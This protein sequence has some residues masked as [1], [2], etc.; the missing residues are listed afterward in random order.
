MKPIKLIM[1]AFGPYAGNTEIDF[2]RMGGRGLYL[3]TGDTG[4]GKTTIFDAIV[5]ALYGEASGEVRRADMF[6]SKY[7]E[8]AVP[9]YVEY[10]FAYREKY[11]T[12]KRNPEYQRPKGRGA[13]YTVQK[14]DAQLIYPDGR[15]PVTKSKEVTRTVTE[16]VG[17]DRKQFTQ[18]AMIAQGDFQKLLFAGTEERSDIFR[19]IFKTSL[20]QRLQEQLKA[21]VKAQW[22]EY[23]ELRRSINQYMDSVVCGGDTP[24]A[25]KLRELQKEKFD[26]RIGDG[27]VLLEELCREDRAALSELDK[28]LEE[29]DVQIQKEDQ[30]IGNIHKIREQ[31]EELQKNQEWLSLQQ[32][33]LAEAEKRCGE[34]RENAKACGSLALQIKEQ[35][36]NL[37]LFD[38]MQKEREALLAQERIIAENI[39]RKQELEEQR[40][41]LEETLR[42]D[43]EN[44]KKLVS[45]GE[46]RER[47]EN[48]KEVN[49]QHRED[50]RQRK[51]GLAQEVVRQ[52]DTE[53]R[54]GK[55]GEKAKSLEVVLEEYR[56]KIERLADRDTMLSSA[57][58]LQK[59]LSEQKEL[60]EK[61]G[62]EW[63]AVKG[64]T[65]QIRQSVAELRSKEAA[66]QEAEEKRKAEQERLKNAGE[67]EIKCGH[68]AEEARERLKIFRRQGDELSGLKEDVKELEKLCGE[69]ENRMQEHQKKQAVLKEEWEA[70]K[71]ADTRRILWEQKEKELEGQRQAQDSLLAEIDKLEIRK[72]ELLQAQEE[73]QKAAVEKEQLSAA[74]QKLE[75]CFLGAQA[76]L[77]AQGLKEGRACPVC[78][79]DHHPM[80]AGVPESV[81]EKKDLDREKKMLS[82]A[83]AKAE[84]LSAQ[85][86]HLL[87]RQDEQRRLVEEQAERLFGAEELF[88]ERRKAGTEEKEQTAQQPDLREM[89][90]ELRQR[91]AKE[92]EQL[93]ESVDRTE[94]EIV[95]KAELEELLSKG[96][97]AQNELDVALH[98]KKQEYAAAKGKLEEKDRQWENFLSELALPG[99]IGRNGDEIEKYLQQILEQS[100]KERKQA[101]KEKDRFEE[102]GK[103]AVREEKE[104][105]ICKE[106][107]AKG[108][109][110]AADLK[111]QDR[112]LQKQLSREL[113]KAEKLLKIAAAMPGIE[114]QERCKEERQSKEEGQS[115]E[116]RQSM[117]KQGM[118]EE[119]ICAAGGRDAEGAE[120]IEGSDRIAE[121]LSAILRVMEEACGRLAMH[122]TGLKGEIAARKRLEAEREEKEAELSQS[123]TDK[124]E[125]EKQLE[126]ISNRRCEKAEQLFRSLCGAVP[127]LAGEY[128]EASMV[129]EG[130]L[131]DLADQAE[132]ELNQ[133]LA[134]LE[135]ELEENRR[136]LLQKQLLDK[137]IPEKEEQSKAF[138]EN[139]RS[140]E[141]MLAG[142]RAACEAG[143]ERME[144]MQK[145]LGTGKREDV[146]ERIRKL[147]VR[148][149]ELE[150]ALKE[151]ERNFADC[152][153]RK[154]RL[155]SAIEILKN[156]LAAAGEAG[157][158]QEEE[159]ME[160]KEGW[161]REKR[162]LSIRR[163]ER[164]HAFAVNEG[165]RRKVKEK[166]EDI[167]RVEKKYVWMKALSDTA[168]GTLSGKRKVELE[169]YI[170]MTYFD[171]IL[172]RANLRLLTMSNRQYELKRDEESEN[173]KEKAGLALS[174]ID[175]YNGT[176]R[177]VKTLSGGESFQASLALALGLSDEIQSHAGG[178][179]M[180]SMFVDEGFGS[181]DEEALSQ[182]MKALVQLTEGN[183]LVGIIS[184][185]SELKEQIEKKIIVTKC[186]DRGGISSRVEVCKDFISG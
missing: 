32:P 40:Q 139:I 68:K 160:R 15:T 78:G 22:K 56:E 21:E 96:E 142:Q 45:A 161:L 20:Y 92:A 94:K 97:T 119:A 79:S 26:G 53:I 98:E 118:A 165:V 14:A 128:P 36:D 89:L 177:S 58:E 71:D 47:L 184:H 153:T 82:A 16:L 134:A 37:A 149:E 145:Q 30:L 113:E 81:P 3:I 126:G 5:F 159:V 101:K 182:A 27:L 28:Q 170:Q 72:G 155:E 121:R 41:K 103:E 154:E 120:N 104:R 19:Q 108:Q 8:D 54:I 7:A 87:T 112:T 52:Q 9:T 66:Y 84:R 13:G 61:E 88:R 131:R 148:R 171:R 180:E 175:H 4:A 162:E 25:V 133:T 86:G 173:R 49:L 39:R 176:E 185:V 169:T 6:R 138:E 93:Q 115:K 179:Q 163:D 55:E 150:N 146:E 38:Q 136:K 59:R 77:L 31:Q 110:R 178:I 123:R 122:L 23:D 116:E 76:G 111:G 132:R 90:A 75:Q 18:I 152:N 141:V 127:R 114:G 130:V 29:L 106:Q 147:D 99:N 172:R 102:L 140:T 105:L 137:Q 51:E 2:T 48:R 143:K 151:A 12:V 158:I 186:R 166:Q 125:L 57:E 50:L 73:Y 63:E 67:T 24:S 95:R 83:E 35:Q 11:Y 80:P 60:L 135:D 10:T 168:N 156:Q 70:V 129:P 46:E 62:T 124:N 34:A 85:A 183:R 144:V 74:Y 157:N 164:N 174:V 69:L 44:L 167:A 42:T 65:E 91:G 33:E 64:E 1:S 107:I 109:E 100:E 181:L 43:R 117:E 17:L